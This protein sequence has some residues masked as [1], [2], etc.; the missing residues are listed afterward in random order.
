MDV[1]LCLLE[2]LEVMR[3]MLLYMREAM[4]GAHYVLELLEVV[5]EGGVACFPMGPCRHATP[6]ATVSHPLGEWKKTM[7]DRCAH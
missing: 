7:V 6:A 5:R 4:D 3:Y 2:V 1:E